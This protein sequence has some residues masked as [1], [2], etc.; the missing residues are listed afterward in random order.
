MLTTLTAFS[1]E[2]L[3]L[4]TLVLGSSP[5]YAD[6]PAPGCKVTGQQSKPLPAWQQPHLLPP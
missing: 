5:L 1:K 6:C 2:P 4:L 3:P